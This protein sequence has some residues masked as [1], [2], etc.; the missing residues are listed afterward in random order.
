MRIAKATQQGRWGK[1]KAVQRLVTHSYYRKMLAVK[2]VMENSV[3]KQV[4]DTGEFYFE[5]Q[6]DNSRLGDVSPPYCV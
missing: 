6:S 4:G 1:V 3:W 2:R 5:Y